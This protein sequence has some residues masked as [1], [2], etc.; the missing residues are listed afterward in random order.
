MSNQINQL[1]FEFN[2]REDIGDTWTNES[3][4]LFAELVI[5]QSIDEFI[6]QLWHHGIDGLFRE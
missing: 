6:G 4:V 5:K 3:K 2:M 1:V